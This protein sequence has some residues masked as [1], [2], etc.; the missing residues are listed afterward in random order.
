M[1]WIPS[2]AEL[3]LVELNQGGRVWAASRLPSCSRPAINAHSM[4][5]RF[6]M[7]LGEHNLIN[8][9]K[10]HWPALPPTTYPCTASGGFD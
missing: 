8:N 9:D 5:I 3:L 4:K 10:L 6:A 2:A 7:R 1:K